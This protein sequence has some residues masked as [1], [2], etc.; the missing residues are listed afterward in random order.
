[1]LKKFRITIDGETFE[2]SVEEMEDK[3]LKIENIR[4]IKENIPV[5]KEPVETKINHTPKTLEKPQEKEAVTESRGTKIVTAPLPGKVLKVNVAP[6]SKIKRGDV[7]MTIEAMK[8]E[9]EILASMNGTINRVFVETGKN[10]E[11]KEKL[12][13][14]E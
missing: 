5:T 9:N 2:V 1:M 13:E 7:L 8:M 3:P 6:G 14:F 11:T 4:E 12:L 10:V